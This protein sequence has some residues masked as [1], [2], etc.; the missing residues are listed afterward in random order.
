MM[1]ADGRVQ[2]R[3]CMICYRYLLD[4]TE[5]AENEWLFYEPA[6]YHE[7]EHDETGE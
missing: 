6:D 3:L 2:K 4:L 5:M 7:E 1:S